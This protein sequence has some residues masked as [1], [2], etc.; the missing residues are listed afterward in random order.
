[1][2]KG[3][4]IG[5]R[6]APWGSALVEAIRGNEVVAAA[7]VDDAN[8]AWLRN[9]EPDT[10]YQWRVTVDGRPWMDG[11][12][13]DWAPGGLRPSDRRADLRFRTHAHADD[14]VPVTF[15]ALGDFGVGLEAGANG[16]RQA[17]V[18]RTIEQLAD[19]H[20]VRFLVSLGDTIYHLGD[21]TTRQ[22]GDEDDDWYLT[23]FQPYR[24]LLDHLPLYPTAGN[25]DGADEEAN[26][27]RAQLEDNLHLAE[28]FLPRA[29]VGRA[30]L[31]P[32]LF[33]RVQVGALLELVCVDTTWGAAQGE[34]WFDDD[35]H[36]RWLEEALP[37]GGGGARWKVP[38]CH[39]PPYCAG[40]HHRSM[41]EQHAS[42]VPLYQRAGVRLVLSGHEHNY[43]HGLVDGIHYVVSGAAGKLQED[44]PFR[45]DDGGTVAWASV[46][47]CLLVEV[48]ADA[49]TVS[50][51]GPGDDGA[52]VLVS[53]AF[54]VEP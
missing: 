15:I 47:H 36:H 16:R 45:F 7:E 17:A 5:A 32:G 8:H 2:R 11:I 37:P 46:P 12:R 43:Q 4:T 53:E 26:D 39:H 20:D 34:H 14:A 29:E 31:G 35:D 50:P 9:L 23:Y 44:P 28:R 18:A 25:H 3:G 41:P 22:S 19:R 30:S 48:T 24:Y 42:L 54:T 51:Y 49:I 13:W 1:L 38:F 27:D 6:S 33:Y 40:P 52:P 21:D 10:E